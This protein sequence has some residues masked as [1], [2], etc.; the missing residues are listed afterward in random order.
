M[1]PKNYESPNFHSFMK[2]LKWK[3]E[4]LTSNVV[5]VLVEDMWI[6]VDVR[7]GNEDQTR[8]RKV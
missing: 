6:V 2:K 1:V 7:D 8:R 5:N 3:N 4:P